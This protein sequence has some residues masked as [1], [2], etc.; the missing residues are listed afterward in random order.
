MIEARPET[1]RGGSQPNGMLKAK[2]FGEY[3]CHTLA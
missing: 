2:A 3:G 1:G